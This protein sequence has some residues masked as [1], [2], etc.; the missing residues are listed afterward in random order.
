M[1][2]EA[3]DVGVLASKTLKVVQ[4]TLAQD[5]LANKVE[6]LEVI[7][8]VE[9]AGD[10][11]EDV[12]LH[13]P[14]D[15]RLAVRRGA[16]E[17]LEPVQNPV[18]A[19]ACDV[20]LNLTPVVAGV[21]REQVD[22]IPQV[23]RARD[24]EG[25]AVEILVQVFESLGSDQRPH[26]IPVLLANASCFRLEFFV[27]PEDQDPMGQ[28]QAFGDHLRRAST[29][30]GGPA[31]LC[32]R[33]WVEVETK[34]RFDDHHAVAISYVGPL[35]SWRGSAHSRRRQLGRDPLLGVGRNGRS[36]FERRVLMV[37]VW[38]SGRKTSAIA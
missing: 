31:T 1:G 19:L 2:V 11:R 35:G 36:H 17:S 16:T 26:F 8:P 33:G 24:E 22:E 10:R 27:I 32:V 34:D 14:L 5:V 9:L 13:V 3:R 12:A 21:I 7:V 6:S 38:C 15:Q 37:G 30:F 29:L 28:W 18:V 25:R 4:E 23:D 20:L